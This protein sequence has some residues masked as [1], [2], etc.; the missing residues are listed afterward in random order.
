MRGVAHF[1][2]GA[3]WQGD[4]QKIDERGRGQQAVHQIAIDLPPV[5]TDA[6]SPQ[7]LFHARAQPGIYIM[8]FR[9]H[10]GSH[11]RAA[12]EIGCDQA[13]HGCDLHAMQMRIRSARD[14]AGDLQPAF[15]ASVVVDV[16]QNRSHGRL[17]VHDGPQWGRVCGDYPYIMLERWRPMPATG[18]FRAR[19]TAMT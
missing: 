2:A 5:P 9:H 14:V 19:R 11:G 15:R 17:H 8:Q 16:Q 12:I 13:G 4:D 6:F 3:L 7:P 10:R 1:R 18:R